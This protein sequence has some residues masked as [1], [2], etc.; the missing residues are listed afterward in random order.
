[1]KNILVLLGNPDLETYSGGVASEYVAT[2]TD[3]GHAVER[4]NIGVT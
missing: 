4:V 1:M 2:A 3:A